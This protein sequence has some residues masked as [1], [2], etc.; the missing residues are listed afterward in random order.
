MHLV[1]TVV[2]GVIVCLLAINQFGRNAISVAKMPPG[3]LAML[4][5]DWSGTVSGTVNSEDGFPIQ[6]A[7]LLVT[8]KTWPDGSYC[9]RAYSAVANSNGR[10]SIAGVCPTNDHYE[11]QVTAI[12]SNHELKSCYK[13]FDTGES[14][15]FYFELGASSGVTL[16]VED[17]FGSPLPNV[18]VLPHERTDRRGNTHSVYFDSGQPMIATTDQQGRVKIPYFRAGDQFTVLI[19]SRGD[20]VP[21]ETIAPATG[22]F[23]SV[24]ATDFSNTH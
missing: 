9:Q 3:L 4:D 22:E 23:A 8:V 7:T 6:G 13:E 5:N 21:L 18:Q 24:R 14:E 12:A 2:M 15:P 1:T 20:W 17:E 11:V 10:F 19:H 16:V